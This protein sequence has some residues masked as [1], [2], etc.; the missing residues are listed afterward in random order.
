M[1]TSYDLS[2]PLTS[3]AGA[4]AQA[5]TWTNAARTDWPRYGWPGP[6]SQYYSGQAV[7]HGS[8]YVDNAAGAGQNHLIMIPPFD[9]T[10]VGAWCVLQYPLGCLSLQQ[11]WEMACEINVGP[12]GFARKPAGLVFGLGRSPWPG[13]PEESS[14]AFGVANRSDSFVVVEFIPDQTTIAGSG[15][16][17]IRYRLPGT[18]SITLHDTGE[19]A[20]DG[21][22]QWPIN[23]D[24]KFRVAYNAST[25]VFTA[26]Q[27]DVAY[28]GISTALSAGTVTSLC[29]QDFLSNPCGEWAFPFIAVSAD[30]TTSALC[31]SIVLKQFWAWGTAGTL[32]MPRAGPPFTGSGQ[33]ADDNINYGAVPGNAIVLDG[34]SAIMTGLPTASVVGVPSTL[35]VEPSTPSLSNVTVTAGQLYPRGNV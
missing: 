1:P 9:N 15:S 26:Y 17:R 24:R 19:A 2:T 21:D 11:N 31:Q 5:A 33:T 13:W 29:T 10:P 22:R 4:V 35:M 12:T 14:N 7:S 30:M 27:Q 34:P 23:A 18:S 25:R 32:K 8:W 6:A 28:E 16:A 20:S 3:V